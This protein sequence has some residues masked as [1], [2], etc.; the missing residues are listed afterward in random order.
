M[1][2]KD[3]ILFTSQDAVPSFGGI[4]GD[5]WAVKTPIIAVD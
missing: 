3:E 2:E 4:R 5:M 1:D